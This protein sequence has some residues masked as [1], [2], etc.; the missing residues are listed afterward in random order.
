MPAPNSTARAAGLSR[1][2]ALLSVSAAASLAGV[3]PS[4]IRAWCSAGYLAETRTAG[5]HRRI[6]YSSLSEFCLTGTPDQESGEAKI[7][8]LAR[9]SSKE[10]ARPK[11]DAECSSLEHQIERLTAHIESKYNRPP[12]LVL[13]RVGSGLRY[14][15][16]VLLDLINK[17]L[18]QELVGST[19]VVTDKTRLCRFG[20]ELLHLIIEE[21][22]G[23]TI[24]YID[25][26][27]DLS[28]VESLTYDVLS[29]MTSYSSKISAQKAAKVLT[30]HMD[31]TTLKLCYTLY[32][33]GYS[34]RE[35]AEHLERI[36]VRTDKGKPFR[37]DTI[38]ARVLA[39][40]DMLESEY[41]TEARTSL[42]V[43]FEER[44]RPTKKTT[45]VQVIDLMNAYRAWAT[46]NKQYVLPKVKCGAVID[47]WVKRRTKATLW[48]IELKQ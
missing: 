10:Q 15:H 48:G 36:G 31:E 41:A 19:I 25:S 47:R 23:A 44:T 18:N 37:K 34:W 2:G 7:I 17:A 33:Q 8:A 35:L 26:G 22:G 20:W 30:L 27:D 14:D 45:G 11:G 16:P 21:K 4:T 9:V 24:E 40:W 42:D 3:S 1:P 46:K 12:D 38:R 32:K 28:E 29:I 43:F 5:G 13:K 39:A 6:S